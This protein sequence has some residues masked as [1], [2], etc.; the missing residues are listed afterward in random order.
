[1]T[2]IYM[3]TLLTLNSLSWTKIRTFTCGNLNIVT[4][5]TYLITEKDETKLWQKNICHMNLRSMRKIISTKDIKG[6]P[7]LNIEESIKYVETVKYANRQKCLTRSS[8]VLPHQKFCSYFPWA[9]WD[10]CKLR[11]FVQEDISLCMLMITQG[12]PRLDFLD[13]NPKLFP[14]LKDY[15]NNCSVWKR[16]GNWKDY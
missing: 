13:K 10:P 7:D 16:K 4:N 1:M 11:V 5:S 15:V 3:S 9:S 2:K 6:I 8:N 14:Y 12:S